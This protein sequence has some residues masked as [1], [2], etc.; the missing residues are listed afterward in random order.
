MNSIIINQKDT[1]KIET[2]MAEDERN[3]VA[4][5]YHTCTTLEDGMVLIAGGGYYNGKDIEKKDSIIIYDSS[6]FLVC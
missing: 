2:V 5:N 3:L 1:L 6:N 4:R